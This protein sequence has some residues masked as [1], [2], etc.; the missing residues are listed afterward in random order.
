MWCISFT[1]AS[2][3]KVDSVGGKIVEICSLL[4]LFCGKT[5][6][7]DFWDFGEKLRCFFGKWRE[8]SGLLLKNGLV[9]REILKKNR[10]FSK[11][12]R[13]CKNNVTEK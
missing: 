13:F 8:N 9:F 4:L 11:N 6:N 1:F 3:L 5:K 7:C 2:G 10:C 12:S